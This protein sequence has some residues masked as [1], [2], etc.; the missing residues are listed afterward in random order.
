MPQTYLS[1]RI[2]ITGAAGAGVSSL[3]RALGAALGV[4]CIDSDDAYWEPTDPPFTAKRP[5]AARR[6]WLLAAQGTGGWIVAG[7]LC[8][9]GDAA[10]VEADLIVFLTVPTELRLERLREREYRAFGDR[11]GPGGDMEHIHSAFLKWAAGY[12]DP[13]FTGRSRVT[14]ESWLREQRAPVLRLDGTEPPEALVAGVL[15]ALKA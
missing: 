12:D 9:W 6:D 13:H 11:I 8:G 15:G 14:H 4:T 2:H 3:G 1:P 5:V 7:S 10:V